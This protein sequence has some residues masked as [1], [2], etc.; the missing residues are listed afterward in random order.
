VFFVYIYIYIYIYIFFF[1]FFFLLYTIVIITV[2]DSFFRI[3]VPPESDPLVSV[4][5]TAGLIAI[6]LSPWQAAAAA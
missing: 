4:T 2:S 5:V 3:S 1:F 6:A